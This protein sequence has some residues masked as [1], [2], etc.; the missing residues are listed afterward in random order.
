MAA[1]PL[2]IVFRGVRYKRNPDGKQ[3]SHRVYYNA[4]RG[5][6]RDTL[7][8]DIWRHAHPSESIPDGW[9]IHH[10]DE[11]PFNNHPVNLALLSHDEHMQVHAG[12]PCSDEQ[13]SHLED[14]RPLAAAWH[15]STEGVAWHREHGRRTWDGREY[16]KC[17]CNECGKVFRTRHSVEARHCSRACLARM[18]RREGRDKRTA[19][20]LVCGSEFAQNKYTSRPETCG[21]MCGSKLAR[22]R[23]T[24]ERTCAGCG[25]AFRTPRANAQACSK[26]CSNALTRRSQKYTVA[27]PCARCGAEFRRSKYR[28][29]PVTCSRSCGHELRQSRAA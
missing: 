25:K 12:A 6:G 4:P 21:R 11:D 7:H 26:P 3:R 9:H 15:S 22:D 23:S 14:I 24:V 18:H 16:R 13:R 5:S 17:A 29:E 20:C 19:S 28:S 1:P 2:S 8:R 27:V 10:E